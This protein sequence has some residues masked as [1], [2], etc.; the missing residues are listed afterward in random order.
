MRYRFLTESIKPALVDSQLDGIASE[1]RRL[2]LASATLDVHQNV[3]M[4]LPAVMPGLLDGLASLAS[5]LQI[6]AGERYPT[7]SAQTVILCL[8]RTAWAIQP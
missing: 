1:S 6:S 8:V 5:T 7:L 3:A 4:R 2:G